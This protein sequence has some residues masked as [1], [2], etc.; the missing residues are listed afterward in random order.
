MNA[1]SYIDL[2]Y[3]DCPNVNALL[4]C[5]WDDGNTSGMAFSEAFAICAYAYSDMDDISIPDNFEYQLL[6]DNI[7]SSEFELYLD[8]LNEVLIE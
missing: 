6:V 5:D 4:Y 2:L 7:D 1:G 3:N 8:I